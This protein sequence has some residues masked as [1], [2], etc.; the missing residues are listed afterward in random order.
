LQ[1]KKK[2]KEK[3]K[4]TVLDEIIEKRNSKGTRKSK[5]TTI[6]AIGTSNYYKFC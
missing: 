6:G 2:E 3:S 5:C 1:G 4:Y